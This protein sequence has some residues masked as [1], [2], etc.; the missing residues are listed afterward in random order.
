M[1]ARLESQSDGTRGGGIPLQVSGHTSVEFIATR[2]V[3]EGIDA[4]GL[5]CSEGSNAGESQVDD[6]T[7]GEA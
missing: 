1:V 4:L 3:Q 6:G 2:G 7:H 5:G